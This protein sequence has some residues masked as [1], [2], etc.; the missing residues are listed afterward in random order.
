MCIRD[1]VE[2]LYPGVVRVA[3]GKHDIPGGVAVTDLNVGMLKAE[4]LAG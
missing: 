1:R 3:S 2:A 4:A